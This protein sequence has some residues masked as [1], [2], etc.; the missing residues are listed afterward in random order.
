MPNYGQMKINGHTS[1]LQA[2][3]PI[4][5]PIWSTVFVLAC[6]TALLSK[7][8]TNDLTT[9]LQKGLFEEEANH[10]L[11]AAKQAYESVI[12][13]FDNDRKLAATA[14]FRL[15]EVYRKQGKTNLASEQYERLVREFPDQGKLVELSQKYASLSSWR[16]AAE[17]DPQKILEEA[18]ADAAA[19]R[20][21]D[22]LTKHVWY[23]ENA[24]KYKSY[25][26][27]FSNA[28]EW[29]Q[30]GVLY[31]P[32]LTK[33]NAVRDD[34]ER[35]LREGEAWRDAFKPFTNLQQINR[36]LEE[37]EKTLALFL[38]LHKNRPSAAKQAWF[39][40]RSL[41]I[42]AKEYAICGN[43]ISASWYDTV[44]NSYQI[45]KGYD[46][47]GIPT[48]HSENHFRTETSILVALLVLN[49]RTAEADQ[50]IQKALNEVNDPDFKAM[51]DT[52]RRGEF[53][54][55]K[56]P[57]PSAFSVPGPVRTL[58]TRT[59][60]EPPIQQPAAKA[61]DSYATASGIIVI[62][63]EQAEWHGTW[64]EGTAS[65]T[66][67]KFGESY[68]WTMSVPQSG[69]NTATFRPIIPRLANYYVDVWHSTG[70][71]R[72]SAAQWEIV[73]SNG[74]ERFVVNQTTLGGQ[75][76]RL[77]KYPFTFAKGTAGYVRLSNKGLAGTVVIA[78]AIRFVPVE[79]DVA[80]GATPLTP[81]PLAMDA[82]TRAAL[83]VEIQKELF[84]NETLL[85]KLQDI[86]LE[87]L[88]DVL[89][90]EFPKEAS[91]KDLLEKKVLTELKLK[92]LHSQYLPEHPDVRH[93]SRVYEEISKQVA[94]KAAGI[95]RSLERRVSVAKEQLQQLK[96]DEASIPSGVSGAP[97][98]E[99]GASHDNGL[100]S[101]QRAALDSQP[102]QIPPRT[103][104]TPR[105]PPPSATP[106]VRDN[107]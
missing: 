55:A 50:I 47:K 26:S 69:T 44:L 23:F 65:L 62:D 80:A 91:L 28:L 22:A 86:P 43:Y 78:D 52:A 30:L 25:L 67:E 57:R 81:V 54:P 11:D 32:A 3:S 60:R 40:A 106:A 99:V 105:V 58:P 19:G 92:R 13:E 29:V 70:P 45:S 17:P 48:E 53:P 6:C 51:L 21:A 83:R 12:R 2:H 87:D 56:V 5:L 76:V 10:N 38:W 14:V 79:A 77:S 100:N 49:N 36:E 75:W 34:I 85:S 107:P 93:T 72:S 73:S 20:Y 37:N 39:A 46:G 101:P 18:K 104:L 35:S 89:A 94:E 9:L 59:L 61:A 24:S 63:S 64:A 66:T 8:A 102:R 68:Y 42:E 96:G 95:M 82:G 71:N 4:R 1:P 33:L 103:L 27:S 15:G 88:P 98:E 7:A 41:L 97:S 16:P 90:T 84:K 31:P 74:N